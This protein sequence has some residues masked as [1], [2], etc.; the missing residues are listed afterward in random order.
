MNNFSL[1]HC[2]D[3]FK[4]FL[5]DSYF[6]LEKFYPVSRELLCLSVPSEKESSVIYGNSILL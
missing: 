3:C 1:Y 5:N 6:S 4:W 2:Y